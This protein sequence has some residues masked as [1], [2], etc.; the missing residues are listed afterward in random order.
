MF[1]L[2][3][4]LVLSAYTRSGP[5]QSNYPIW[6]MGRK[7]YEIREGEFTAD[8]A[9]KDISET[10]SLCVTTIGGRALTRPLHHFP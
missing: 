3:E 1:L 4:I 6:V 8:T 10:L 2:S 7:Y 5:R 9:N